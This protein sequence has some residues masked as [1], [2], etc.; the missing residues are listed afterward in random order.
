MFHLFNMS[1]LE[2]KIFLVYCTFLTCNTVHYLHLAFP[3]F[4]LFWWIKWDCI[5]VWAWGHLVQRK[6]AEFG[7]FYH[8][9]QKYKKNHSISIHWCSRIMLFQLSL[10]Y[11][12]VCHPTTWRQSHNFGCW[13]CVQMNGNTCVTGTSGTSVCLGRASRK[14]SL[15]SLWLEQNIFKVNTGIK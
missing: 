4:N 2:K 12:W 8:F 1:F 14:T 10:G 3:S 13:D 5:D 9:M 15:E 7:I 6:N 11:K